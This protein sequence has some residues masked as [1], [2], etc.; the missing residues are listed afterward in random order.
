MP[1]Q[2]TFELPGT[3]VPLSELVPGQDADFFALLSSKEQLTTKD[4]KPYFKVAFRD[5]GREVS[6]PIWSDSPL[7]VPC[8]DEWTVGDFF[9]IRAVYRETSYGPQLDIQKIRTVVNEDRDDGFDPAICV[10]STRFDV[11]E[12]FAELTELV[13]ETIRDADVA[14]LVISLLRSNEEIIKTLPAATHNH[15]AHRGG[16][17]EHVLSVTKTC[18]Y[19]AEKYA[20]MYPD[21]NPP[22]DGDLVVAGG[23]LHDIGKIRELSATPVGAEYTAAGTLIGHVLQG[24]DMLREAAAECSIDPE[25]L[26]RLEHVIVAHQRLPEWGAPKPPMTPEALLVHYADDA[27]AKLQMMVAAL[28][29]DAGEGPV[30]SSRNARRQRL[31]RGGGVESPEVD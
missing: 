18:A 1:T 15:H 3:T 24:R 11:D 19:F 22:L 13:E 9:K 21:L 27:D 25:K 20:A 16:F 8:R 10:A 2:R 26:L 31:Y 29:E 30:T 28:V 6:F 4:G 17:L 14:A 12:M 5:A 23:A 7:A